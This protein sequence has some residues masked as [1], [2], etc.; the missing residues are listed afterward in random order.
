M[1]DKRERSKPAPTKVTIRMLKERCG[2]LE[3]HVRLRGYATAD[4]LAEY[5][6]GGE[7][8]PGPK[9]L[10]SWIWWLAQLTRFAGREEVMGGQGGSTGHQEA[11]ALILDALRNA[12]KELSFPSLEDGP[13]SK[14]FA[15]V[16]GCDECEGEWPAPRI[17][18]VYPKSLDALMW[19]HA[20]DELLKWQ[21][22]QYDVLRE[23]GGAKEMD[24]LERVTAAMAREY[25]LLMWAV[26]TEG[27]RL[28]KELVEQEHPDPPE[29]TDIQP[30]EMLLV[31][32][33]HMEVNGERLHAIER[34]LAPAKADEKQLQRPS[35]SV[36]VGQM[37]I[38]MKVQPAKLMKD[39]SLGELLATA[40]VSQPPYDP[41]KKP[42]KSKTA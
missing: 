40:K 34:L 4:E 27:P 12:P 14:H 15:K 26:T 31:A 19:C 36:F 7:T 18:S 5:R 24:M 13:C 41:E 1:T 33:A 29:Y 37:A 28:P 32:K 30:L 9:T 11:D 16:E 10:W 22:A 6:P 2:I 17:M 20:R 23:Y 38:Q 39:F 42:K 21:T 8:N 35:W 25:R 3:D